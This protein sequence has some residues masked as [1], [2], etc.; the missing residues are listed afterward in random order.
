MRVRRNRGAIATSRGNALRGQGM[1]DRVRVECRAAAL[2]S[3]QNRMK[4]N[5]HT[6]AQLLQEGGGGWQGRSER[7]NRG[8][9]GGLVNWG[10]GRGRR[11]REEG[12]RRDRGGSARRRRYGPGLRQSNGLP[13]DGVTIVERLDHLLR[14]VRSQAQSRKLERRDHRWSHRGRDSR[15]RGHRSCRG[16]PVASIAPSRR[17]SGAACGARARQL[18][19]THQPRVLIPLVPA[20]PGCTPATARRLDTTPTPRKSS[21][22]PES[23][24]GSGWNQAESSSP[25]APCSGQ[26]DQI[27]KTHHARGPTSKQANRMKKNSRRR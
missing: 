21:P 14:H 24:W 19:E 26:A 4:I 9:W 7:L 23:K 3:V 2:A 16:R 20:P 1:H 13:A 15:H 8:R 22:P 11:R 17:R 6:C 27:R 12:G 5:V 25:E 18:K 10:G